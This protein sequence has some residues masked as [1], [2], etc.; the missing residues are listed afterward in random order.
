MGRFRL[1]RLFFVVALI[2][3][4]GIMNGVHAGE[5]LY[6]ASSEAKT[7][8][9]YEVNDVTGE[10]TQKFSI[11]LPGKLGPLAFSP[12]MSLIYAA[13]TGL[14]GDKA[15]VSTLK[16]A[17]DG[18]LTIVA[19]SNITA[20]SPYICVDKTGKFLLAAHYGP[21]EVT[22]YRI[23]DGVCTDELLDRKKTAKTAH[24]IEVDPSGRFV[25]VPHTQPNKMYQFILDLQTGK[26]TPNDPP[27]VD[28]PDTDHSYHGP[29]HY[30]HHPTLNFGYTANETGG[31]ITRWK[32]DPEKG[33]LTRMETI[34]TIPPDF[35]GASAGADMRVTPDGRFAYMSNRDASPNETKKDTLAG[36][37]LDP[38]TG[39]MKLIGHFPAAHMPRSFCI[40]L[41]GRF[42]YSAG[43]N[44]AQLYAHRMH[45]PTGKLEHFA[46]YKT[47][48]VPIWVMCGPIS[49]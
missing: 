48:G 6:L 47:G 3:S 13:Q 25:F 43:Q 45:A 28:G 2:V 19:T 9:T 11:D 26:L 24:C 30:A 15:G 39:A 23:T 21:G 1:F 36:V 31:G 29:R 17:A 27:F 34:Y 5:V 46:T 20:R 38:E 37:S 8:V 18:S 40:S 33:T 32:F 4:S 7:V 22:V 44:T 10:L 12:D 41:S 42:V 14:E 49:Q 35:K 16:R